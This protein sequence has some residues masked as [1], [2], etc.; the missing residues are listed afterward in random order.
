MFCSFMSCG[1]SVAGCDFCFYF[2]AT[3][4][5]SA[6]PSACVG[7]CSLG[8][9]GSCSSLVGTSIIKTFFQKTQKLG[10]PIVSSEKFYR[11]VLFHL[12]NHDT[13]MVSLQKYQSI[14]GYLSCKVYSSGNITDI[15]LNQIEERALLLFQNQFGFSSL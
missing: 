2:L 1:A 13:C 4:N 9:F 10:T 14:K 6:G 15:F 12:I 3:Y 11:H 5:V 7:G 8:T